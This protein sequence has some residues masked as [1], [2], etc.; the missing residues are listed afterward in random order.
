VQWCL[1]SEL[2]EISDHTRDHK[3]FFES[4]VKPNIPDGVPFQVEVTELHNTIGLYIGYFRELTDAQIADSFSQ[5]R[6]DDEPCWR[7]AFTALP[8]CLLR[9]GQRRFDPA[10]GLDPILSPGRMSVRRSARRCPVIAASR[11]LRTAATA[12]PRAERA[13]IAPP[14]CRMGPRPGSACRPRR[15]RSGSGIA[16]PCPAVR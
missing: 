6:F 9:I 12:A 5:V 1:A 7:R 15:R 10:D 14:G 2:S 8:G 4:A 11:A 16:R 13:R 3:T